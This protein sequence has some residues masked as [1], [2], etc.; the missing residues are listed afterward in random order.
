MDSQY[1]YSHTVPFMHSF[2]YLHAYRE[3]RVTASKPV[4]VRESQSNL[5]KHVDTG[6]STTEIIVP[7]PAYDLTPQPT[8]P[9]APAYDLTPQPTAP[10]A[11]AYDFTPQPTAPPAPAYDLTPQPTAAPMP[12]APT[13]GPAVHEETRYVQLGA[14]DEVREKVRRPPPHS[15]TSPRP[16]RPPPPT[17]KP[18]RPDPP[19]RPANT[20]PKPHPPGPSPRPKPRPPPPPKP[21]VAMGNLETGLFVREVKYL[22]VNAVLTIIYDRVCY[23]SCR[24]CGYTSEHY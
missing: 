7:P 2:T 18:G 16:T 13:Q 3:Q 8:A 12:P 9:P 20:L 24:L 15:E 10:P 22:C 17:K 1:A 11:P 19:A 4:T 21:A 14:Q 5:L 6:L 23:C